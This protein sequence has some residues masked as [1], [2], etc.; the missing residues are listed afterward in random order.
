MYPQ[1]CPDL[2]GMASKMAANHA[3]VA[4]YAETLTGRVDALVEA[5]VRGDW[6]EVRDQTE[7]LAQSSRGTGHRAVSALCQ[8]VCTELDSPNNELG[9]RRSIV[10]LIGTCGRVSPP[11]KR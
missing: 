11:A 4:E 2:A 3:R 8:R 7:R 9:I 10:R 6:S 5:T 1:E